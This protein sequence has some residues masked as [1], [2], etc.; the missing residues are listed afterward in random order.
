MNNATNQQDRGYP[1]SLRCQ[2]GKSDH[3]DRVRRRLEFQL[4]RQDNRN[5]AGSLCSRPQPSVLGRGR[6]SQQDKEQQTQLQLH[7]MIQ[8]GRCLSEDLIGWSL[9]GRG[10]QRH[11]QCRKQIDLRNISP[12]HRWLELTS[13][14]RGLMKCKVMIFNPCSLRV[15]GLLSCEVLCCE[16]RRITEWRFCCRHLS[17]RQKMCG[18][19][20]LE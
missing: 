3:E 2:L 14:S 9:L 10:S 5:P 15:L 4:C 20:V 6:T 1:C 19:S 12:P 13:R 8:V 7:S 16:Y 17:Q 11:S 18:I